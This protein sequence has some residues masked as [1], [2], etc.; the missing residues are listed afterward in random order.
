M[1]APKPDINDYPYY[2]V[3]GLK[4]TNNLISNFTI[5]LSVKIPY[6]EGLVLSNNKLSHLGPLRGQ[7]VFENMN[8]IKSLWLDGNSFQTVPLLGPIFKSLETLHFESNSF[9]SF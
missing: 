5:A 4:M 2:N 3:I 7:R 8:R 9:K 1:T 6:V